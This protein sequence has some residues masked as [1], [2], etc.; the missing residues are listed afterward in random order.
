M[1]KRVAEVSN[2]VAIVARK[3][4]GYCS[5]GIKEGDKI[6]IRGPNVSLEETD[7]ICGYAFSN[8]FP[9]VFALRLGVNLRD[10]DLEGRLWQC[11]DP[12]PPHTPGGRVLFEVVPLEKK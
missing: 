2:D 5:A 3:V 1:T 11:V 4:E 6:V 12:G 7:V 9:A 10:L 8:V